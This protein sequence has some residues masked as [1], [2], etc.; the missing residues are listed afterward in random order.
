MVEIIK[1]YQK[2]SNVIDANEKWIEE[3]Y[4]AHETEMLLILQAAIK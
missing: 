3:G 4:K 1:Q 2:D